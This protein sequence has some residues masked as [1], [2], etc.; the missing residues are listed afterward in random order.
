MGQIHKVFLLVLGMTVAGAASA[1]WNPFKKETSAESGVS[2]PDVAEAIAAFKSSDP[3]M[4]AFFDK[5]AGYAIFPTVAKGGMGIGGA[6]GKG[7]VFEKGRFVGKTTLTQLTIG[8]QLG[9]QAYRE[10]IF[11]GNQSALKRFKSGTF[12]I[13]AQVSAVAVTAGAS[14]DADYS[15]GVAIFT[16]TKGGLMYEATV[17]GQKFTYNAN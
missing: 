13:G 8:F 2:T 12:E 3:S 1:G 11:F 9:G 4:Q 6:Y 16:L 5:A 10:I 17:G 15:N 14:A 7:Q